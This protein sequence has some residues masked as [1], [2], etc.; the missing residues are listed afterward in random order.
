[1][2][3]I[4]EIQQIFTIMSFEDLLTDIKRFIDVTK[5]E[6]ENQKF[7]RLYCF[8]EHVDENDLSVE[9]MNDDP[10]ISSYEIFYKKNPFVNVIH[11]EHENHRLEIYDEE[12]F[13]N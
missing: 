13:N 1:M 2:F 4:K 7:K 10:D 11:D 5:N 8:L 6:E 9:K 3:I 12:I